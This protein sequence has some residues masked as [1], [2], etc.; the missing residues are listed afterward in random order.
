MTTQQHHKDIVPDVVELAT[1]D[2]YLG[3][4]WLRQHNPFMDWRTGVLRFEKCNHF[5]ALQPA[6]RQ[7]TMAD[8]KMNVQWNFTSK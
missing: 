8:E 4:L 6:D 2:I 7:R 5:T 1:Q 3:M